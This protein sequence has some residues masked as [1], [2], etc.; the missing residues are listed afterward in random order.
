MSERVNGTIAVYPQGDAWA[1][2]MRPYVTDELNNDKSDILDM[3]RKRIKERGIKPADIRR[4]GVTSWTP[5]KH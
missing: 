5:E 1:I 4:A 3:V 2:R